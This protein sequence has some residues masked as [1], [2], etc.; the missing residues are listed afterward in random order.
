MGLFDSIR[1][2]KAEIEASK[3]LVASTI[4]PPARVKDAPY[5]LASYLGDIANARFW[6]DIEIEPF[7]EDIEDYSGIGK[8]SYDVSFPKEAYSFYKL[9]DE[10]RSDLN[11]TFNPAVSTTTTLKL[12][13]VALVKPVKVIQS[14]TI[15]LTD[16]AKLVLI[17]SEH[18]SHKAR[19]TLYPA[20]HCRNGTTYAFTEDSKELYNQFLAY[21]EDIKGTSI[22]DITD[23]TFRYME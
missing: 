23:G 10:N 1:K 9:L 4:P 2:K 20:V 15:R 19:I 14:A 8:D 22:E 18:R 12:E 7:Y 5:N 3:T 21:L 11:S 16:S 6:Q 17:V 13:Y